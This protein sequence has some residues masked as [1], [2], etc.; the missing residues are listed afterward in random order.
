LPDEKNFLQSIKLEISRKF[1]LV[2]YER[3]AFHKILGMLRNDTSR[4]LLL[5]ELK[6]GSDIRH[7]A[8]SALTDFNHPEVTDTLCNFLHENIT[9]SEAIAILDNIEKNGSEKHHEAILEYIRKKSEDKN[10]LLPVAKAFN[11]LKTTGS[12]SDNVLT[13]LQSIVRSPET[14][15][16]FKAQAIKSLSPFRVISTFEEL[17]KDDDDTVCRAVYEALYELNNSVNEEAERKKTASEIE[18]T[19]SQETE[20]EILLD[21][22]VLLGKKTQKFDSYSN[23]TKT[24]FISAMLACNHREYLIYT[25][26]ALTSKDHE[27]INMTLFAIYRD[28]N[29]LRDPDKLFRNLISLSTEIS[30][31]NDLILNIFIRYFTSEKDNRQYHILQDKL[32]SFIVVTLEAYFENYRK[33]FMVRDVIEKGYPEN[34][35]L[36]RTFILEK[37][38]PDF[39]KK[40]LNFLIHD[41]ADS[42]SHIL[43]DLSKW[44]YFVEDKNHDLLKEFLLILADRDPVS[45][46]NSASRFEDINFEKRYLRNRILRL[47]RIISS[48]KIKDG[49]TAL[50]SIYNYLKKYPDD[51]IMDITVHSL[52]S[53]NYSYMLGELEIMLTAGT[54]PEQIKALKYLSLYTEQRSL[55]ILL[56]FI[57][58]NISN[59]K[60]IL[61]SALCILLGRDISGNATAD[62]ILKKIIE[63][64]SNPD[65]RKQAILGIGKCGGELNIDYLDSLFY[66]ESGAALK[67]SIVRA[68]ARIITAKT[69]YNKRMLIK[70]LQEYLKDPGIRV[71]IYSCLMLVHLGDKN[72]LRSIREML[73]IK[74]QSVQREILTTMGNLKSIEFS[75][76]LVSLLSEEYGISNDIINVLK[77][78]PEDDMK[79]I[80]GFI[81]NIF[82]KYEAPDFDSPA[83]HEDKAVKITGLKQEEKTALRIDF[84]YRNDTEDFQNISDLIAANIAIQKF[85]ILEITEY[86]GI[87]TRLSSSSTLAMFTEPE[88]ALNASMKIR[89]NLNNYNCTRV[90]GNEL[91]MTARIITDSVIEINNELMHYAEYKTNAFGLLPYINPIILDDKTR[92]KAGGKFDAA[93]IPQFLYRPGMSSSLFHVLKNPVN[94]MDVSEECIIYIEDETRQMAEKQIQLNAEIKRLRSES[95]SR[96]SMVMARE[97]DEIG[98]KLKEQLDEI[99]KY[100]QRRSTDRELLRNMQKM[101]TNTYNLYKVEISRIIVR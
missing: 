91:N 15:P 5:N 71:R 54:E 44:I 27:L 99:E 89:D 24:A 84:E 57:Q 42:I 23:R 69:S 39:K 70:K 22:R 13:F 96:S 9:V 64:N 7:S 38:T 37:F 46:K 31:D 6:K 10:N 49:A 36:V 2:P 26:K 17:L 87:I 28:I 88:N 45:R 12:G 98:L 58:H 100:I 32:Y 83:V 4:E 95:G 8:I 61:E 72:A 76:F 3:I 1:R 11:V 16:E 30:D 40:I 79:E 82:R 68:I 97:L 48:L 63:L 20:D 101:L 33:E 94:F 74:N 73:I 78:L 60:T 25:M 66:D 47:C 90:T 34:F 35:Q 86:N 85:I 51:I 19:Y 21:I 50:V 41:E 93:K 59:E 92:E 55:N 81:I 77:M 56:E 65:I 67:D 62:S 75:F 53:L 18:F 14:D 80:E 43:N 29:R 52:S